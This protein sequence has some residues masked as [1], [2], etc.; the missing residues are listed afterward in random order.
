[1]GKEGLT[2]S[3]NNQVSTFLKQVIDEGSLSEKEYRIIQT[4]LDEI[5]KGTDL[6]RV[7]F[8]L[9]T[10]LSELSVKQELSKNGLN[11]LSE[12][13]RREPSTSVSSMWNFMMKRDK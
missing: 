6:N 4:C 3:R 7:L 1:M 11:C 9:K 2:V 13:S 5:T 8:T 12:I 10:S